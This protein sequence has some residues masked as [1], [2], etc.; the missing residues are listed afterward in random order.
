[1]R[2]SAILTLALLL[3]GP[4]VF[5]AEGDPAKPAKSAA[6]T[7]TLTPVETE[8]TEVQSTF[9]AAYNAG[10]AKTLAAFFTS[11]ADWIDDQGAIMRGR[12]AVQRAL[13]DSIAAHKGR[14]LTLRLDSV[15]TLGP[16]V[17]VGNATSTFA[18]ADKST[19]TAAFIAIWVKQ[20]GKWLISVLTE[21]SEIEEDE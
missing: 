13:E 20:D 9:V 21:T 6:A 17:V 1:M 11:D 3:S 19:E 4:C 15:R 16:D 18:G 5:G 14:A 2:S 8:L 12:A 7:R 10:D